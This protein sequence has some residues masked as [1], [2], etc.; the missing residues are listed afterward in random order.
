[1]HHG[2]SI[3]LMTGRPGLKE[4]RSAPRSEAGK[5]PSSRGRRCWLRAFLAGGLCVVVAGVGL[6]WWAARRQMVVEMQDAPMGG[7][8]DPDRITVAAGTTVEWKNVGEQPHGATDDSTIA[9]RA[10]DAAYPAG[11]KPFDSGI[12]PPGQSFTYTFE[13]PGTYKYV[14]LPHEFGGMTGEVIVTK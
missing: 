3:G 5:L 13:V 10:G 14:C 4:D 9:L 12:L 8:F 7:F 2:W 11:A 6:A 1:M